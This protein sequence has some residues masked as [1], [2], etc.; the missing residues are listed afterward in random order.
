MQFLSEGPW[1]KH[2]EID[3]EFL[4]NTT[5]EPYTLHT[6]IFV[7]GNGSKEQQFRLWFDPA[8]DFHTYSIVWTPHHI[9]ILVDGTPLREFRNHTDRGVAYPASQRMRLYGSLWNADDWATQGGRVKTNWTMAPF[10]AQYR[11]FTATTSSSGG[12]AYYDQEMDGRARQ[13][14][15]RARDKYMIYNYCTDTKRFPN[16]GPPECSM[17]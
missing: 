8:A 4:G 6:N 9:L 17:P 15:K 12:Y 1:E 5:G 3:L 2:D 13:D 16:G 14:M 10:V 7:N 11:D